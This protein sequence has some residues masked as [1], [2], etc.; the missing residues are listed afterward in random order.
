MKTKFTVK[1]LINAGLYTL[2]IFVATFVGGMIG[3][4][5]YTMPLVPFIGGLVG[6][7]IFMLYSTKIHHFGLVLIMGTLIGL[8]FMATGHGVYILP[9][10]MFLSLLAEWVLHQGNYQSIK[11]AR[12]AFTVY[13][14]ASIF[15]FIPIFL[16]RDAYIAKV[17]EQ[18]YG[19]EF[20]DK[21]MS[22]LPNWSLL[23]IVLLGAVG[24]YLGATIG[25][26][27]LHKHFNKVSL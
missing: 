12:W 27:M 15:N 16:N 18:G 14:L 19:Q 13:S 5:P 1:D 6:G 8:F 21:M 22:V 23:P 9:E 17:V 24:G 7:P 26:K 4:I 20:A 25:I 3:F 2:L 10:T 11:H